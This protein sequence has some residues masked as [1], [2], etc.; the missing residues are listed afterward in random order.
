MCHAATYHAAIVSGAHI[1]FF[2]NNGGE[3]HV[4]SL[5]KGKLYKTGWLEKTFPTHPTHSTYCTKKH[6]EN[7]SPTVTNLPPGD[8]FL[9]SSGRC[10][11]GPFLHQECYDGRALYKEKACSWLGGPRPE[12]VQSPRRLS[13]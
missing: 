1:F 11:V 2:S 6:R 5:K 12:G 3:L 10:R 13:Y 9:K 7:K 8:K 4:I